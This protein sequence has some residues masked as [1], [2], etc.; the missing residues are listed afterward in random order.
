MRS[1]W[2]HFERVGRVSILHVSGYVDRRVEQ[3]FERAVQEAAAGAADSVLI[4]SLLECSSLT[5]SC[6]LSLSC[7][8]EVE[9][10]PV[11]VV[12]APGSE[13]RR[14][15]E[16]PELGGLPVHDGFREAFL[17]IATP[18]LRNQPDRQ[19]GTLA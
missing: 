15:F 16:L 1:A 2:F 12:A 18:S 6:L 8:S 5:Y 11:H 10:R 13:A 9:Q 19:V 7:L 4:V 3:R 17:S 14:M